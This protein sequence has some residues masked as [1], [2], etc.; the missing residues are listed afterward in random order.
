M[1]C[2]IHTCPRKCHNPRD[3]KD[4]ACPVRVQ[5]ELPCGHKVGRRCHQSKASDSCFKC[6]IARHKAEQGKA[7]EEKEAVTSDRPSTP[8]NPRSPTFPTFSTSPASP[9]SPT[10]SWR[11]RHAAAATDNRTWRNGRPADHP[12]NVFSM[13]RGLRQN[14][15]GDK[16]GLFGKLKL[17][18]GSFYSSRG[19][20]HGGSWRK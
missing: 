7:S 11:D 10:S 20:S 16:G 17:Q 12:T 18:S 19:G 2:G 14:T 3:H 9:T 6:E 1:S 5:T 8:I 4:L 13:H 15:D